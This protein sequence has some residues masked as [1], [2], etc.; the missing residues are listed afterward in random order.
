MIETMTNQAIQEAS[1]C[2]RK[3]V[4]DVMGDEEAIYHAYPELTPENQD[5]VFKFYA[6]LK[7]RRNDRPRSGLGKRP[8][9]DGYEAG[10]NV[11]D[12]PIEGEYIQPLLLVLF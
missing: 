4:E 3:R 10:V 6:V 7:Q 9:N 8:L 5:R 12:P 2:I 1:G 11:Y